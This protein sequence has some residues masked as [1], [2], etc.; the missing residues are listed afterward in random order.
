MTCLAYCVALAKPNPGI[1]HQFR[2]TAVDPPN[3]TPP[4]LPKSPGSVGVSIKRPMDSHPTFDNR[5][6]KRTNNSV[7]LAPPTPPTSVSVRAH[8][9]SDI[10]PKD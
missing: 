2:G 6:S 10:S 9:L 5:S 7:P 8:T 3:T 4:A 1:F